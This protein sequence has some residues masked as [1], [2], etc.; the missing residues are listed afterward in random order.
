MIIPCRIS[1]TSSDGLLF[2]DRAAGHGEL[3]AVDGRGNISLVAQYN[4]W[5]RTWDAIVFGVLA[6][7]G[8]ILDLSLL[9]Y[10]R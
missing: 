8:P 5:R 4:N 1:D 9:F 7:S 10:E 2:Y 3:Y 6:G